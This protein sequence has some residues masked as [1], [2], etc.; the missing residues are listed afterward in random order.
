MIAL[1]SLRLPAL[2]LLALLGACATQAPTPPSPA[3]APAHFKETGV[4][5]H[6]ATLGADAVPTRWWT[7]FQDPVLNDLQERLL[8]GNESL[9]TS[10]AALASAQAAYQ[11][12]L[13]ATAPKLSV[14]LGAA[15]NA[16]PTATTSALAS[17][18]SNSAS[19]SASASWEVDVWGRLAQA[20]QGANASV[21][22]SASD[23]A[24][25]RLS[26]QSSLVQS[27]FSLRMAEAQLGLLQRTVV[28]GQRALTLTQA[29]Y[30]AG[31][32]LR[33]DVLQAQ[34]QLNSTQAQVA[35]IT[36]QRAQLEH[37]IA[38]LLGQAPVALRL[39]ATGELPAALQVPELLPTNLLQRR[40]DIAAAQARV[41]ASYAQLGV[42]DAA[43]FPSV[44]LSTNAG[45]SHNALAGLV[46][47][48]NFLWGLGSSV[49]LSILDG[50]QHQLASAQ[51]RAAADQAT[52]SYRQT[53]LTALQEVEDNLVLAHQLQLEQAS[54]A[55]ALQAAQRN[56]QIT[57]DQYQAGTVSYLNV[58]SAQTAALSSESSLL[59]VRNRQLAT[60]NVLL[61]NLAGPWQ[62]ADLLR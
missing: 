50:G 23:L 11:A 17:N 25:A 60:V 41:V 9:K 5:Q 49:A 39:A 40:P 54:Q 57:L 10:A 1:P 35:E 53:V 31:V 15:R 7:L 42:A 28:A 44:S 48:P 56:L 26:L 27:Y 24:A 43:F 33:T 20:S 2:G 32:A 13:R 37:A 45:Y 16:S 52:A 62:A 58:V 47:A 6:A 36:A 38:L 22:A 59:A 46:N 21:L 14:G 8:L 29:R 18:P 3:P 4:W 34:T 30:D 61:K 51:A 19:L 12:S 55:A